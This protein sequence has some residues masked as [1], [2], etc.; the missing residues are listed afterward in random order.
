MNVRHLIK[1]FILFLTP[2]LLLVLPPV[3]A[4][5][6]G[7]SAI[8]AAIRAW[9]GKP[10]APAYEYLFVDLN[11]DHIADA[12]IL[13]TDNEY[14][15]TGG[16]T[17]VVLRGDSEQF[18]LVSSS[19]ITRKPILFLQEVRNG[20]HTL[21]V[22]VEGG[23]IAPGQVMMRFARNR[24]PGNPTMQPRAKQSDLEAARTLELRTRS[25]PVRGRP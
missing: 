23:G 20:W 14:C 25:V 2:G 12:V 16:C 17:M 11:G 1:N 9:A 8:D 7:E 18:H 3:R 6:A 10:T 5:A 21:S 19:T 13:I 15:G 24:Y 4:L 22:R